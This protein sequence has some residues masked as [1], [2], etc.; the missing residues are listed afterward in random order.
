MRATAKA[1]GLFQQF[2]LLQTFCQQ[3]LARRHPGQ[4]WLTLYRGTQDADDYR[5]LAAEAEGVG[6][7]ECNNVSSFT[8]DSE[9]AWEFGSSVWAV[10]VP[11]TK[12][13]CFSGLLPP[14]FLQGESE[15][16]VLGG[17]YRVRRL[18]G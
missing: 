6:L 4:S 13:V 17:M 9:V 2:D 14:E 18:I 8:S 3:E 16:L 1:A 5:T 10:Q 12:V 15:Y 7:I 11:I